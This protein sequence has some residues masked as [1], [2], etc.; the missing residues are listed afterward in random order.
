M[1]PLT[2]EEAESYVNDP[3]NYLEI[4]EFHV[5]P[6]AVNFEGF[7]YPIYRPGWPATFSE[8]L[9]HAVVTARGN[10][11]QLFKSVQEIKEAYDRFIGACVWD[12]DTY[13]VVPG[14]DW[15]DEEV[16]A[17]LYVSFFHEMRGCWLDFSGKRYKSAASKLSFAFSHLLLLDAAKMAADHRSI[18]IAVRARLGRAGARKRHA[19]TNAVR[20]WLNAQ[21]A[22]ERA[23]YNGNKSAFARAYVPKLKVD[24]G[25]EVTEKTIREIWLKGSPSAGK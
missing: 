8:G 15:T 13:G 20:G 21:W 5:K 3:D 10:A 16:M 24:H 2:R 19:E 25:V 9:H 18:E 4:P 7:L 11:M 12:E 1:K 22:L 14:R 17:H 23:A 6:P